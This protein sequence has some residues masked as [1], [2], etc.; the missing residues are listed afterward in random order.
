M[1]GARC[2]C[3]FA[4]AAGVDERIGD[5][6]REVFTPDD[7]TGPDGKAHLEGK[8]SLFCVCGAGGSAQKLDSHFLEVFRPGDSVGR[9]GA[10]HRP[11]T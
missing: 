9:D 6:L 8:T 4:E 2:S 5:H 1:A 7:D 10:E 11:V 3:G